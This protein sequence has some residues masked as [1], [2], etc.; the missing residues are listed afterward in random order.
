MPAAALALAYWLHLLA[1]VTW[2][3]GLAVLVLVVPRVTRGEPEGARL[4]E[5]LHRPLATLGLLSLTVLI[6]TGMMQLVGEKPPNYQGVLNFST[7]WSQVILAKHLVIAGMAALL[8][9]TQASVDPA[10]RRL[11]WLAQAG[12]GDPERAAA[13]R[14]RRL[15]VAGAS[16]ALGVVVLLLTAIATAL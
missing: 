14:R 5:A 11:E 1:T 7:L 8:A 13:L 16:L 15:Q 12:R 3:G 10:L 6:A 9:Y 4:A 2:L